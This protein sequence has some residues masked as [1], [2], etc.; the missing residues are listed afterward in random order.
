MGCSFPNCIL[1][2]RL[3]NFILELLFAW[4]NLRGE[5][6]VSSFLFSS[7]QAP[8]LNKEWTENKNLGQRLVWG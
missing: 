8:L 5:D 6:N 3:N 2:Y 1:E 7:H 4:R